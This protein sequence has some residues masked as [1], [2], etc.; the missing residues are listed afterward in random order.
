MALSNVEIIAHNK[1]VLL[2]RVRLRQGKMTL[3]YYPRPRGLVGSLLSRD[4]N[5]YSPPSTGA[6]S[7]ATTPIAAENTNVDVIHREGAGSLYE[8]ALSPYTPRYA[9]SEVPE[10]LSLLLPKERF[11]LMM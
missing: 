4:G 5:I 9:A 7:T 11:R 10:S 1:S 6:K 3:S 8:I 2:E